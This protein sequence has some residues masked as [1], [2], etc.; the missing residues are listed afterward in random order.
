[1]C[2]G[3]PAAWQSGRIETRIWSVSFESKRLGTSPVFRML[4]M[5]STNDSLTICV[6]ENRKTVGFPSSPAASSSFLRS[7]RH[8]PLP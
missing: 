5:S 1:M 3:R 4:L 2:K 7:S 8:S 6:S